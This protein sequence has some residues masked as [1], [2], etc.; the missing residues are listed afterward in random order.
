M[1]ITN[2]AE[3]GLQ[4]ATLLRGSWHAQP[5]ILADEHSLHETLPF[6]CRGGAAALTWWRVRNSALAD[7][8]IAHEL[9]AAYRQ[10]R[11]SARIHEQEI[12]DTFTRLREFDIEPVLIKGW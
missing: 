2:Q 9:R 6:L 3:L 10:F 5:P 8:P 4:V 12:C 7:S 1:F 11:L